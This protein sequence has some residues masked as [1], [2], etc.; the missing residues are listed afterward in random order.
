[1]EKS[2]PLIQMIDRPGK[3]L[4]IRVFHYERSSNILNQFPDAVIRRAVNKSRTREEDRLLTAARSLSREGYRIVDNHV[5]YQRC[6]KVQAE[7]RAEALR[8]L[9][10]RRFPQQHNH[11]LPPERELAS[12]AFTPPDTRKYELSLTEMMSRDVGAGR[13]EPSLSSPDLSRGR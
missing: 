1:M 6:L 3:P 9:K 4:A 10:V 8:S 12:A 7:M 11:R 2:R 13:Y 5:T